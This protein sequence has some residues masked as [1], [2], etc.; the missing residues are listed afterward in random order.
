M[1]QKRSQCTGSGV[2]LSAVILHERGSGEQDASQEHLV[3][4]YHTRAS[5]VSLGPCTVGRNL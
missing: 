1:V 4:G 2:V 5:Y 3:H